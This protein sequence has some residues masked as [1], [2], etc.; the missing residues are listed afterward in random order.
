ML[1]KLIMLVNFFVF[2]VCAAPRAAQET[3]ID[4]EEQSKDR[5]LNRDLIKFYFKKGETSDEVLI[6]YVQSFT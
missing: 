2:A 6:E 3:A 4:G 1:R 5:A